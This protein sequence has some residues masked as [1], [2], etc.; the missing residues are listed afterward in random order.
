MIAVTHLSDRI[1]VG[2]YLLAF[3][4]CLACWIGAV[5]Q[6]EAEAR[7]LERASKEDAWNTPTLLA[8]AVFLLLG[9]CVRAG[10]FVVTG[11]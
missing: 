3:L 5:W 6:L 8:I 9:S 7:R 1:S 10:I 4:L 2:V 11:L